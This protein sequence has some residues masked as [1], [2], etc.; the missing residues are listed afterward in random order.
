MAKSAADTA[1]FAELDEGLTLAIKHYQEW[2]SYAGTDALL[3]R[4]LNESTINNEVALKITPFT[5]QAEQFI[6]Q[7][8]MAARRIV[9]D[10]AADLQRMVQFY[11][12]G[13]LALTL[14]VLFLMWQ[15]RR[16]VSQPLRGLRDLL[17]QLAR[18]RSVTV[19]G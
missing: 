8:R 11:S 5:E 13:G 7:Q 16:A 9:R 12:Y 17:L 6:L 4:I 15:T 19:T 2:L 18:G 3:I 10:S 1:V 14:L